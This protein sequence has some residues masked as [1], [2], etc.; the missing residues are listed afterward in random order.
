MPAQK[1]QE[2]DPPIARWEWALVALAVAAAVGFGAT[3]LDRPSLWHDELFHVFVAK[4]VAENGQAVLPSGAPCT[5]ATMYHVLLGGVDPGFL[6]C[7]VAFAAAVIVY[8]TYGGFRAVVWTDVLQGLVMVCGVLIML[9]LALWQIGGLN[10]ATD[11]LA[12]MTPPLERIAHLRSPDRRSH[13]AE[14]DDG[15]PA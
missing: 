6:L 5:S 1:R 15:L 8:T 11:E 4:N 12:K 14:E 9:P 13:H 7:L 2:S 10:R 3:N